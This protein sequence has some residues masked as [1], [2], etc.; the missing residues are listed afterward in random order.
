[1]VLF[2]GCYLDIQVPVYTNRVKGFAEVQYSYRDEVKQ[3]KF[4][5]NIRAEF[6]I[7][8][9]IW[10]NLSR[11]FDQNATL[12]ISKLLAKFNLKLTFPEKYKYF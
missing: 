8:D 10:V 1:M 9:G 7:I 11:G 2:A 4:L 6:N 3:N 5:I 12:K